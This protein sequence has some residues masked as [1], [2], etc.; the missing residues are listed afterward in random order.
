MNDIIFKITPYLFVLIVIFVIITNKNSNYQKIQKDVFNY[1]VIPSL[2]YFAIGHLVFYKKVRE[3][4]GW[5]NDKGVEI[6]QREIGIVELTLFAAACFTTSDPK[7]VSIIFGLMLVLFGFNH[8]STSGYENID[9]AIF[10]ILYGSML[11]YIYT[12][13]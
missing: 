4:Q 5:S 7:Y 12:R 13:K 9:I 11:L 3:D 10:D 1:S 8:I 6:L 2:A